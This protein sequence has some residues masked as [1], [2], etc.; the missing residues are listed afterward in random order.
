M[1]PVT[2]LIEYFNGD[3][4]SIQKYSIAEYSRD[5]DEYMC[6]EFVLEDHGGEYQGNLQL[7]ATRLS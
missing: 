7:I 6:E 4:M 5:T 2:Y 3:T 1:A